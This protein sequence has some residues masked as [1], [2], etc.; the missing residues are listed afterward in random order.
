MIRYML[1]VC[2]AMAT[3]GCGPHV[4]GGPSEPEIE[5]NVASDCDDGNECTGERCTLD[6]QCVITPIGGACLES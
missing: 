2:A 6:G 3:S 1:L 4:V 5:C